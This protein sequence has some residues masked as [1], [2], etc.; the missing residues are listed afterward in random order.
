[1]QEYTFIKDYKHQDIYRKSF[2]DLGKRIFEID[3]EEFYQKGYWG[4]DY[5]CY[6]F[7]HEDVV[8]SNV[9]LST[10][11]LI[12]QGKH[13]PAI[14]IGTVMT[15]PLY[16]RKGLAYQLM[17]KIFEVY[18]PTCT[19]YFLAADDEAIPLYEKCGFKANPENKYVV[20]VTNY[21]K[22][23]QKI[24]PC[25]LSDK[26]LLNIKLQA[27][28]LSNTLSAVKD[29]HI[30]MFYYMMGFDQ[31]IYKL[32]NDIYVIFEKDNTTINLYTVL[33]EKPFDLQDIIESIVTEDIE[34]V[35]CHFTPD[36]VLTDLSTELDLT[37]R[38]MV[39]STSDITFPDLA[40][41]PQISQT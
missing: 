14:Q 29:A 28:P 4:D 26:E 27:Q 40:R 39:R 19:L 1:M 36:Q 13:V 32:V 17:M 6:S 18:D 7:V 8:I 21:V 41:F 30:L 31:L 33:S 38:W 20:D 11:E 22:K 15:D 12:I 24:S 10:M 25:I 16:R 2:V 9:S 23:N 34:K 5:I 37:S 35:V 3:F